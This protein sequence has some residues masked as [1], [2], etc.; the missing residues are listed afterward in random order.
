MA[1]ETVVHHRAMLLDKASSMPRPWPRG[2]VTLSLSIALG[3]CVEL[4]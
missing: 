3:M 1:T 2:Q 4:F